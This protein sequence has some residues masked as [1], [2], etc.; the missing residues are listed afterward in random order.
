MEEILHQFIWRI[1]RYL[2]SFIHLMWFLVDFVHQQYLIKPMVVWSMWFGLKM[3]HWSLARSFWYIIQDHC[4]DCPWRF[5][6]S[7]RAWMKPQ[8]VLLSVLTPE[9][10]GDLLKAGW[11]DVSKEDSPNE[12]LLHVEPTEHSCCGLVFSCSH[13]ESWNGKLV[14]AFNHEVP[15]STHHLVLSNQFKDTRQNWGP[16]GLKV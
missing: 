13:S 8:K 6:S 10:P 12:L 1:Y 2:Q 5:V 3:Q 14:V 7:W 16:P 9:V 4:P 11:L 15:W